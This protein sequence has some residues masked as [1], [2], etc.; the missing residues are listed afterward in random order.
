MPATM[1]TTGTATP[2][3]VFAVPESPPE[4][5][6]EPEPEGEEPPGLVPPELIPF[7]RGS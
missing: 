4:P 5:E 3:A 7:R 1:T 6:L 2:R